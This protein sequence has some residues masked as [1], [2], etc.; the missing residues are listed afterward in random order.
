[1]A[2]QRDIDERRR[3][4]RLML[5]SF[6]DYT[7]V[8]EAIVTRYGVSDRTAK[9][10][11]KVVREHWWDD[12]GDYLF[13]V[14]IE[15]DVLGELLGTA[16][17]NGEAALA[18]SLSQQRSRLRKE[19]QQYERVQSSGLEDPGIS[20]TLAAALSDLNGSSTPE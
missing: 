19:I 4:V 16:K 13:D 6:A 7:Y 8:V 5:K 12:S 11:I 15:Y 17:Q 2:T 14:R 20:T 18:A 1:M 3:A 10:D 9:T